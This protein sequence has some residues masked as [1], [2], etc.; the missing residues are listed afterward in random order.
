MFAS[1]RY[2]IGTTVYINP[3]LPAPTAVPDPLN[4]H[5]ARAARAAAQRNGA[6][7]PVTA[8]RSN[9]LRRDPLRSELGEPTDRSRE[10]I[11]SRAQFQRETAELLGYG[12][13]NLFFV[14]RFAQ[15]E[16]PDNRPSVAHE[17]AAA[18]YPSLAFDDDILL[19][20]EAVP[21]G[22]YG[23]PRLDILV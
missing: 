16:D 17:T 12:A 1:I 15:E 22:W 5:A 4:G 21:V 19:P 7:E 10:E 6:N 14:Q 3:H 2:G 20:G 18:A 23:A 8:Y 9:R 13:T 11:R